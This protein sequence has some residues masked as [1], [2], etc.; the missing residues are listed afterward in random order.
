MV[1]TK[2]HMDTHRALVAKHLQKVCEF[3]IKMSIVFPVA[4]ALA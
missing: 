4:A 3:V 2:E 1:D